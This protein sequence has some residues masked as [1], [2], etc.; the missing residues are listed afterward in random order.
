MMGLMASDRAAVNLDGARPSEVWTVTGPVHSWI[1]L[2]R[3]TLGGCDCNSMHMAH[4]GLNCLAGLIHV[5]FL[6]SSI[7]LFH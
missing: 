2:I 1:A 6:Q 5:N 4:P 7:N 3:L